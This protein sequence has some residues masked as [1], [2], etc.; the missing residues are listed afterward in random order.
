RF[1]CADGTWST[2]QALGLSVDLRQHL[3]DQA[4][5]YRR[6]P[7]ED[8]HRV[9]GVATREFFFDD[10]QDR[11]GRRSHSEASGRG[12]KLAIAWSSCVGSVGTLLVRNSSAKLL[13]VLSME[14]ASAA[15][16]FK[17]G[18]AVLVPLRPLVTFDELV[19]VSA[20]VTAVHHK[21]NQ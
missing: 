6:Q 1:S 13:G 8:D 18:Y 12:C 17:V 11:V 14:R 10:G 3:R 16:T 2:R 4:R 7:I 5:R 21:H 9:L 19:T 15:G 20:V